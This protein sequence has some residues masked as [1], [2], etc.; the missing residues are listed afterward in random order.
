MKLVHPK[1]KNIVEL[2]EQQINVLVIENPILLYELVMDIKRQLENQDGDTVLSIHDKPVS[3]YKYADITTDVLSLEFNNRKILS[4]I[5]T[6]IEKRSMDDV[7]YE[8]TQQLMMQIEMYINEL[9]LE[10]DSEIECEKMTF[11]H[12]LK[13]AGI[14]VADDY[15]YLTDKIYAYMELIREFEGDKLFIFVNLSSY[16]GLEQMQKFADTVI[17]HSYRVLLIDSHD[18]YR[19]NN[20][21]RLIVDQDLCEF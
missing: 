10:F 14:T 7:Y 4:K 13:A 15:E 16:V 9:S 2:S 6:S 18:F 17:G 1:I 21:K 8:Q 19:L 5:I 3:F 11:Q 20:E 12:I